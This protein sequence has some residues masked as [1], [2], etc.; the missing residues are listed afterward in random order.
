M[1]GAEPL[2]F[3]SRK[4]QQILEHPPVSG[5]IEEWPPCLRDT[6]Q[7]SNIVSLKDITHQVHPRVPIIDMN[8]NA[9]C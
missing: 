1:Y 8:G 5:I 2:S 6:T 4:V 9:V 3:Y 7:S